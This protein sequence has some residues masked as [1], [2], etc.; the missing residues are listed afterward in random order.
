MTTP[1]SL[2]FDT[3][4]IHPTVEVDGRKADLVAPETNEGDA[5]LVDQS[6]QE[7][8]GAPEVGRS[9]KNVHERTSVAGLG[10]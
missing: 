3:L 1:S 5:S 9:L 4:C 7:A 10:S 2:G 6:A 8:L